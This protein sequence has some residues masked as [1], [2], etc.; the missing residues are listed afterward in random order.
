VRPVPVVLFAGAVIVALSALGVL[1][2]GCDTA[3]RMADQTVFNADKNVWTYEQFHRQHSQYQQYTKQEKE[4]SLR[5]AELEAK[6]IR[7]GQRY[8]NLATELDG[9]RAMKNRIAA[10]Y[11]AMSDIAYQ[12]IW[13]SRGLPQKLE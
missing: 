2:R 11:N 10:D 9:V 6:N 4:V 7:S 1:G 8:D 13:R 12:G 3:S 5:I